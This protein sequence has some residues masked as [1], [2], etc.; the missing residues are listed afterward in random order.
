MPARTT[1]TLPEDV[2]SFVQQHTGC[3]NAA[4]ALRTFVEEQAF[5]VAWAEGMRQLSDEDLDVMVQNML[6]SGGFLDTET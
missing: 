3:N 6:V 2:L 4:T 1:V 5:A